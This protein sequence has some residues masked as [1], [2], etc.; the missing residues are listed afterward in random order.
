MTNI[1]RLEM[2]FVSVNQIS[3]ISDDAVNYEIEYY[4]NYVNTYPLY[5]V[6]NDVDVYFSYIDEE[7]YLVFTLTDKNKEMLENYKEL[8][9]KV[10]EEIRTI[11]GGIEPF[12]FKKD[13]MKI[14][15][16]SDNELPSKKIMNVSVCIIIA[17]SVFET[18]GKFYP[19]V[20]LHSCCLKYY[21]DTNS[22]VTVKL[23]QNV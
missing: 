4:G 12:E 5:L 3:F 6:F 22:Y 14:G 17:R 1:K 21:H 16:E 19:Q 13:V 8:W 7:K 2:S 9:D 20:Y 15:F 18:N 23:H 11:K 10:K